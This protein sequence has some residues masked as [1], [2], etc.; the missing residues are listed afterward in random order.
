M[1]LSISV[2]L[3][4]TSLLNYYIVIIV[5]ILKSLLNYISIDIGMQKNSWPQDN[6][7]LSRDTDQRNVWTPVQI[8]I[9]NPIVWTRLASI[10]GYK[11]S[12]F[13]PIKYNST[14]VVH[15]DQF[16]CL[17][18]RNDTGMESKV[19]SIY[20]NDELCQ[21]LAPL[22]TSSKCHKDLT[23]VNYDYIA[24]VARK[25]LLFMTIKL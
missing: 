14:E 24:I 17:S 22:Y 5:H 21:G 9:V 4:L 12:E 20:L 16:V 8:P 13:S 19:Y 10:S 25:F 6:T 2:N 7:M 23:I 1:K 11:T 3:P 18:L 15:F